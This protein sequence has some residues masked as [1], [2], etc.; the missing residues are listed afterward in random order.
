MSKLV[1][2]C[3]TAVFLFLCLPTMKW[4]ENRTSVGTSVSLVLRPCLTTT[5]MVRIP[6]FLH[7]PRENDWK[8]V[9][10]EAG[11]KQFTTLIKDLTRRQEELRSCSLKGINVSKEPENGSSRSLPLAANIPNKTVSSPRKPPT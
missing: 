5:R 7:R 10:G 8:R 6:E 2:L 4:Q 1:Q 9:K 11:R 3:C